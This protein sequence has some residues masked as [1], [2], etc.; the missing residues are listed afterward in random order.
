M[1][2]DTELYKRMG[3][4]I[5]QRRLELG[6]T[7]VEASLILQIPQTTLSDYETGSR[8]ARLGRIVEIASRYKT[9]PCE[10]AFGVVGG[11]R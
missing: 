4:R 10:L 5:R 1:M 11:S 6:W 7:Q 8:R 2:D 9:T 3:A